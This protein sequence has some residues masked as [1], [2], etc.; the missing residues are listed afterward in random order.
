MAIVILVFTAI[1]AIQAPKIIKDKNGKEILCF[2]TLFLV[3][4]ALNLLLSAGIDLPSPIEVIMD[5]LDAIHL[6]Y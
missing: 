4:F 5:F 6:H 2:I 1:A 3:G